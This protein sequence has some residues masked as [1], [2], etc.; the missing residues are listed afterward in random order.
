MQDRSPAA[1][2]PAQA[3]G[4]P[5][6][7]FEKEGLLGKVLIRAYP[8]FRPP[9]FS[10]RQKVSLVIYFPLQLQGRNSIFRQRLIPSPGDGSPQDPGG[11]SWG[12]PSMGPPRVP[13]T[14]PTPVGCGEMSSEAQDYQPQT[15]LGGHGMESFGVRRGSLVPSSQGGLGTPVPNQPVCCPIQS[16]F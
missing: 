12:H 10:Q 16:G 5:K 4:S 2:E 1:A 11:L 15:W 7:R 9:C 14:S 8:G 3:A 6:N 13:G